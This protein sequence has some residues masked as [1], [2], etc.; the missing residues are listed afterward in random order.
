MLVELAAFGAAEAVLFATYQGTEAVFHWSVHFFVGLT[1]AALW[2]SLYL[3]LRARPAPGQLTAVLVWH[4][5]A[6]APDAVFPPES[7]TSC[8]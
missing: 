7:P 8:G 1:A 3:A 6:M 4:L 2:H 5:V